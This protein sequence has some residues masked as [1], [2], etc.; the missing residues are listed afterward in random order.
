MA[1]DL[2][3]ICDTP[4][5]AAWTEYPEYPFCTRRCKL[6]D[7]GRWLNEDYKIPDKDARDRSTPGDGPAPDAPE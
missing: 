2:C 1:K 3:P 6:I 5:P 7:L 4:M